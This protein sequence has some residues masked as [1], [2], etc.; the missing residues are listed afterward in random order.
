MDFFFQYVKH[1]M[2]YVTMS[3]YILNNVQLHTH[4]KNP[5]PKS[6]EFYSNWQQQMNSLDIEIDHNLNLTHLIYV[7]YYT[8]YS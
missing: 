8:L 4:L 1:Q 7:K 3:S 5:E 2:E 6:K